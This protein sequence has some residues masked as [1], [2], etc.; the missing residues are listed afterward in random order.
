MFESN[1]N[2]GVNMKFSNGFEV[3]IQ[4]GES[5]YCTTISQSPER[6]ISTSAE[7]AIY[8][9]NNKM[10]EVFP[11]YGGNNDSVEGWLGADDVAKVI[12]IVSNAGN[13][14]QI[15]VGLANMRYNKHGSNYA[16]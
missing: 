13:R 12:D 10:I 14:A 7:M 9:P 16:K 6:T 8:D 2:K 1:M 15:E 5:N 11:S 4:F 3:S